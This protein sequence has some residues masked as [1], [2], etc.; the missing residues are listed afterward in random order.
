M[1]Y[2]TEMLL[3]AANNGTNE[4]FVKL[5]SIHAYIL[6]FTL[7]GYGMTGL[8]KKEKVVFNLLL[9]STETGWLYSSWHLYILCIHDRK[10]DVCLCPKFH[11]SAYE[12]K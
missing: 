3:T 12:L 2:S 10:E 5:F 4:I 7:L 6:C 11:R 8:A 9:Y 1:E